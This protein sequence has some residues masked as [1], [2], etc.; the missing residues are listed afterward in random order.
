MFLRGL[1]LEL[2]VYGSMGN[3][4]KICGPISTFQLWMAKILYGWEIRKATKKQGLYRH[5]RAEVTEMMKRDLRAVS[6]ILGKKKYICGDEPC[7]DDCAI[8]GIL[9]GPLWNLPGSVYETL[10]NGEILANTLMNTLR[11]FI[12]VFFR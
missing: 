6:K 11:Q 1:R 9:S 2:F 8:F 12:I 4:K 10:I 5:T 7:E 3:L